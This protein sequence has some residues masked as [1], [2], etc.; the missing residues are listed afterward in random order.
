MVGD[1]GFSRCLELSG[2]AVFSRCL[3]PCGLAVNCLQQFVGRSSGNRPRRARRTLPTIAT[4]QLRARSDWLFNYPQRQ[5][6]PFASDQK[7]S[8]PGIRFVSH[9]HNDS[10]SQIEVIRQCRV[11]STQLQKRDLAIDQRL[12]GES[13]QPNAPIAGNLQTLR[14]CERGLSR[15]NT[16]PY[17]WQHLE[18]GAAFTSRL[19][20]IFGDLTSDPV[21]RLGVARLSRSTTFELR[22]SQDRKKFLR[23]LRRDRIVAHLQSV[24]H[25]LGASELRLNR[26]PGEQSETDAEQSNQPSRLSRHGTNSKT[27]AS[28]QK[29]V[30][31][32][33]NS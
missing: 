20:P 31:K 29:R 6:R 7:R 14:P 2:L 8:P 16:K 13:V 21:S 4:Q 23:L 9:E 28:K 32:Q 26:T 3:E 19:E 22:T 1:D 27:A 15:V 12:V 18:I 24:T 33:S 10:F 30:A 25:R 11:C 17:H 5:R